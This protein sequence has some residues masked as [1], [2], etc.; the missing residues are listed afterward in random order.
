M[1]EKELKCL[2]IGDLHFQTSNLDE[3]DIFTKRVIK[4]VSKY[5]PDF[6]VILGDLLHTHEII[7]TMP[8]ILV[9]KLVEQ[10]SHLCHV[11]VLIGNHD[12]INNSQFLSTNHV[13]GPLKRWPNVSIVDQPIL[14]KIRNLTFIFCPYVPTGRFI[15]ALDT[16]VSDSD[17]W[18]LADCIFAHQSFAG[19]KSNGIELKGD[20]WDQDYPPIISGHIHESQTVGDNIFYPGSAL[21]DRYDESDKRLWLV[22]F[23]HDDPPYF[24]YKKINLML[25]PKKTIEIN[26]DDVEKFDTGILQKSYIRLMITGSNEKIIVFKK[27][28]IYKK[29]LAA[30]IKLDFVPQDSIIFHDVEAKQIVSFESILKEV[31]DKKSE[32]VKQ[33]Y[34]R[35]VR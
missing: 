13:F 31:V 29:L 9:C 4:I 25:K 33:I 27:K 6:V 3:A 24:T 2:V 19:A 16:L 20:Y 10:L 7:R 1:A 32:C 30:G 18:D 28:P 12:Y 5:K 23:G 8:Y 14:K 26:V 34:D 35:F 21:A 11:Y 15:E 17:S 22:Q